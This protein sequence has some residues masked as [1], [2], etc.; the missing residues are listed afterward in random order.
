MGPQP[1][2]LVFLLA[3]HVP[4]KRF[5]ERCDANLEELLRFFF[6]AGI[7][8]EASLM[9]LVLCPRRERMSFLKENFIDRMTL[10]EML[11]FNEDCELNA[12]VFA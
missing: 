11:V 3:G 8:D 9:A 6:E 12:R 1:A 2:A 5:T 4:V 7:N 10:E